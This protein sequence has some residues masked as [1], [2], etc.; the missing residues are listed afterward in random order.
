MN[1]RVRNSVFETNSSSTHS[2]TVSQDEIVEPAL[3]KETLR[4]GVIEVRPHDFG[5]EWMR[6][7]T[8]EEKIGYLLVQLCRNSSLGKP[9]EFGCYAAVLKEENPQ[10]KF[11]IETIEEE[12]GCTVRVHYPPNSAYIEGDSYGVG[13]EVLNSR[14]DLA[15]FVLSK[16]SYVETGNDNSPCGEFIDTDL[17]EP[18]EYYTGNYVDDCQYEDEFVVEIG[19]SSG[20]VK[21]K[22]EGFELDTM[23]DYGGA[24][25]II[26]ALDGS[27][28]VGARVALNAVCVEEEAVQSSRDVLHQ[29]LNWSSNYGERGVK[30]LRAAPV[31]GEP[32]EKRGELDMYDCRYEMV[33]RAPSHVLEAVREAFLDVASRNNWVAQ[34]R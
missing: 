9:D 17:G 29:F 13:F 5:W 28:C 26:E 33:C 12:T 7:F 19:P 32:A 27:V 3:S 22:M 24:L 18:V 23:T 8:P 6:Y 34:T 25:K 14:E 15:R 2:V 20:P 30:F 4:T 1:L 31:K 16:A 21:I 11:L 10:A